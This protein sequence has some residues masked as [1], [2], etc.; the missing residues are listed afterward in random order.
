MQI[1]PGCGEENPDKFRVCGFCGTALAPAEPQP[2]E[3]QTV[4]C[5]ACGEANPAKFRLC[6]FCGEAL[7]PALPAQE[8]RKTVSIVFSD[9]KGSTAMGEKLDSEAVRE[10][11]SRYFDEMRAALQAHGGTIEKYIGDAIMAVFGL[12]TLHEDDALRAVRAAA[13]MRDRLA[14]LNAELMD[15]W[16][17][18]VGN[19]TGVNTGEVV[20]G[21]PTTGQRLVTGDTV[22]TTAR[23][24]QAAPTNEVLLGETTYRLVRHAVEVEEVE[25]LELKG[26]AERVPA[27]RLVS[28]QQTETVERRHDNPLV[29]RVEELE[30]LEREF[31]AATETGECRLVTLLAD[32]GVGKS[33][34]IEEV[35]RRTAVHGGRLVRG[36]CLPYGRGITFWPLLEI[37][38]EAAAITDDESPEQALQKLLELA[39][40]D[41]EDAVARVA[42]AIGIA[43]GEFPLDELF[44]GTRRLLE[45][46]AARQPL[47]VAFE[48]IHW[49]EDA[50]LDLIEQ[51]AAN[52]SAPLVLLCASRPD[53][54]DR[55]SDWRDHHPNVIELAPL[56]DDESAR[57]AENLLGDAALP[58]T[59]RKRIVEAAEGN[60]LF[61]EQLLSMLIDD[62]LLR[63][64]D[65]RW[66]PAGDMSELAI[67][68]TIQ[69]LLTARLDLLSPQERAV[70]EP[71]S[72]IGLMFEQAAV[73]ELAPEVVQAEVAVHLDTL[74]GKQLVRR[75]P[76]ADDLYRFHHILIRDAAYGGILK[77]ARAT[78]HE[79]FA[80]WAERVNRERGRETEFEE[81]LGYHLEQAQTYLS[82][83]G[84]LDDHGQEL[85]R[86]AAGYLASA[87]RRAFG[88]G[89]QHAAANLLRRAVALLAE[90]SRQRVELLP[91]LAE[92]RLHVGEFEDAQHTVEEALAGAAALG[93]QALEADAALTG[94]LV[95]HHT[96]DLDVWRAEV[97]RETA[98]II[99]LLDAEHSPGVLAKAWR[100]VSFVHALVCRWEETGL[101]SQQAMEFAAAAGDRTREAGAASSLAYALGHGPTSVSDAVPRIEA[102]VAN[103]FP[104]GL[105][106]AI[107]LL[108]LGQ[109]YAMSGRFDEA[110]EL[111]DRACR[112]IEER[113]G[114]VLGN[115]TSISGPS[116][117][118]LL[119]GRPE[120]AEAQLRR[121]HE[122]LTALEENY[123][124]P[125]VGAVWAQA[126]F[127]LG[128]LDEADAVALAA[129]ELAAETDVEPQAVWR[130]VRAKV[131]ARSGHAGEALALAEQAVL[132]TRTT[133]A[134][135]MQADA[136]LDLADVHRLG[137]RI[138]EAAEAAGEARMRYGLKGHTVG[139]QRA[140]AM[141]ERIGRPNAWAARSEEERA[142]HTTS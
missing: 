127:E 27:Y 16:G 3:P 126:L 69:A 97:D 136:L 58:E 79:R 124:R 103:G 22:N 119:A 83:L 63:Q 117:V 87:G 56:S 37:V 134:P 112:L 114:G 125:S 68:G 95:R 10:V 99:P 123:Y 139:A 133:D 84:P 29:G 20:A 77:R 40:P 108:E 52:A 78:M 142:A 44:F 53:L 102:I 76:D 129:G 12:P 60:P 96:D 141:L 137:G 138:D 72:V 85:G 14:A 66:V 132:L 86:R 98:R 18:T 110:R 54:L 24:E 70:V 71:A 45:L 13:E 25:P 116:R 8:V 17:V 26:K 101:A 100:M 93:D 118:E 51:V 128:R 64:E 111:C 30:T 131:L 89:D 82:E 9:L 73:R 28:V 48:D 34:L 105:A 57:V 36:R 33:R 19:R 31:A 39:G 140:E 109:L 23:L 35:G 50:L 61:V 88:R 91:L 21:D 15:R 130:S 106:E 62:G 32:A 120:V 42:S 47:V 11:M 1:C 43:D 2:A 4:T 59:A 107:I 55:R 104:N 80:D 49:A 6:G 113:G 135:V 67:P 92:S 94:L 5:P 74:S 41:G 121:D 65:G 122:A 81:I 46:I 115:V 90:G 75:Q 38:R 7:A